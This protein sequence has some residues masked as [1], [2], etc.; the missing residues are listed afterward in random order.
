MDS[1]FT[2]NR[3]NR[4]YVMAFGIMVIFIS[5]F[6]VIYYVSTHRVG[7]GGIVSGTILGFIVLIMVIIAIFHFLNYGTNPSSSIHTEYSDPLFH[8]KRN[9]PDEHSYSP[10]M[11]SNTINILDEHSYSPPM[12]FNTINILD[13]HSYS[14]PLFNESSIINS[15]SNETSNTFIPLSHT[16]ATIQLNPHVSHEPIEYIEPVQNVPEIIEP[17]SEQYNVTTRIF[18]TTRRP[19]L[20]PELI[21]ERTVQEEEDTEFPVENIEPVQKINNPPYYYTQEDDPYYARNNQLNFLNKN[22]NTETVSPQSTYYTNKENSVSPFVDNE[23]DDEPN[24][25]VIS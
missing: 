4:P 1:L 7:T 6:I 3:D 16:D 15:E 19:A 9:I 25:C 11:G 22:T 5:I 21:S 18:P 2:K 8:Y 23:D 20:V 24:I 17:P 10:P 12:G 13:E 14:P